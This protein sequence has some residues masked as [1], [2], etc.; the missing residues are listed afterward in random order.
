[1]TEKPGE[2][3]RKNIPPATAPAHSLK[4]LVLTALIIIGVVALGL[5][6]VNQYLEFRYKATFL[7]TPCDLCKELNPRLDSYFKSA[8]TVYTDPLG[9]EI[10]PEEYK[11]G[12]NKKNNY[13]INFTWI[14]PTD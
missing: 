13:Q 10:T 8:L 7:S 12:V 11:E 3:E 14:D 1:M 4:D 9:N 6:A 5:V 2:R